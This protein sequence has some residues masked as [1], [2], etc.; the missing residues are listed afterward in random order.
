[1]VPAA[2]GYALRQEIAGSRLV[3]LEGSRHA[4]MIDSPRRVNRALVGFLGEH[5]MAVD[6][7]VRGYRGHGLGI[8][9]RWKNGRAS[10]VSWSGASKLTA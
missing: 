10:W 3:V 4:P 8:R 9:G 2:L 7:G 1:M 6:P 5:G